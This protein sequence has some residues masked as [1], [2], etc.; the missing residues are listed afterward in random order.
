MSESRHTMGTVTKASP[1]KRELRVNLRAGFEPALEQLNCLDLALPDGEEM[2]CRIAKVRFGG[3]DAIVQL[4]A[5]VTRDNVARMKASVVLAPEGYR[6]GDNAEL[7]LTELAGFEVQTE[8]G[9]VFGNVVASLDTKA[10]GILEIERGDGTSVLLPAIPEVIT[11]IDW[12][13]EVIAIG[14]V[15]PFAVENDEDSDTR[16]A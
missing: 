6:P 2:R 13:G 9:E 7:D 4:V 11:G 8:S 12:D 14:D 15:A 1:A 5:G 16:M 3:G 10:G